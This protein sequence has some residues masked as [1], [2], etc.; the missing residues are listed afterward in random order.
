MPV[1]RCCGPAARASPA[2]A[3]GAG[4]GGHPRRGTPPPPASPL[5]AGSAIFSPPLTLF[6]FSVISNNVTAS[7][8]S[9][10]QSRKKPMLTLIKKIPSGPHREELSTQPLA[11]PLPPPPPACHFKGRPGAIGFHQGRGALPQVVPPLPRSPPLQLGETGSD[12]GL[13]PGRFPSAGELDL[14]I[15]CFFKLIFLYW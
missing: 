4:L 12:R 13:D 3:Q 15:F 6:L 1:S 11:P 8:E 9:I 5:S 2:L 14:A 7:L 10:H